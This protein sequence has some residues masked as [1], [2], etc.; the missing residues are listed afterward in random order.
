MRIEA[1]K[2]YQNFLNDLKNKNFD[3]EPVELFG[4]GDLQQTEAY[5]IIKDL[6]FLMNMQENNF[7]IAS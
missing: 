5:N 6:I 7:K 1:N 3:S 4:Q 2:N